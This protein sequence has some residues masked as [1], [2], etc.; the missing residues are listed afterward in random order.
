MTPLVLSGPEDVAWVR[1][2]RQACSDPFLLV[3]GQTL[4]CVKDLMRHAGALVA[5]DTGILHLGAAVGLRGVRLWGPTRAETKTS[6]L[7]CHID[8]GKPYA[9]RETCDLGGWE[10]CSQHECLGDIQSGEVI[11]ALNQLLGDPR[12]PAPTR[13][14]A[15]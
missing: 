13:P 10:R 11:A 3:E 9:C 15:A 1:Q 2:L 6:A 8:L 7:Q 14:S 5:I 4:G 12:S